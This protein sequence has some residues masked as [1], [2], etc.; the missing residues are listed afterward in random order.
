MSE[1]EWQLLGFILGILSASIA[2]ASLLP[3]GGAQRIHL[4]DGRVSPFGGL[5]GFAPWAIIVV[6]FVLIA[7][8]VMFVSALGLGMFDIAA[9]LV[10]GAVGVSVVAFALVVSRSLEEGREK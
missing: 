3:V 4:R 8:G 7:P 6:P 9:L 5:R 2:Y 1:T 10:S